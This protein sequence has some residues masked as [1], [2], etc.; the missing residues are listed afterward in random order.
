MFFREVPKE[1]TKTG[2][3]K[4]DLEETVNKLVDKGFMV[5]VIFAPV[6]S[7]GII[8]NVGKD[9]HWAETKVTVSDLAKVEKHGIPASELVAS[10]VERLA[11]D[12]EIRIK[13][14]QKSRLI[15]NGGGCGPDGCMIHYPEDLDD[16]EEVDDGR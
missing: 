10:E 3:L 5:Q 9:T 6:P 8:V 7:G 4:G 11:T 13:N 12:V 16:V 15:K 2:I 1:E 14:A